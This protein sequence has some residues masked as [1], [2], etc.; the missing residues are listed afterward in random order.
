M[1]PFPPFQHLE[2][3]DLYS[4]CGQF[5][6]LTL[7]VQCSAQEHPTTATKRL[8]QFVWISGRSKACQSWTGFI[9][10]YRNLTK[11]FRWMLSLKRCSN[12]LLRLFSW[13]ISRLCLRSCITGLNRW[14]CYG[15]G[16]MIS[17]ATVGCKVSYGGIGA[18]LVCRCC[19]TGC[20]YHIWYL[21]FETHVASSCHE[22]DWLPLLVQLVLIIARLAKVKASEWRLA[23]DERWYT[24]FPIS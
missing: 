23:R 8:S 4:H 5:W 21:M 22:K 19:W 13:S 9:L 15:T 7:R 14:I 16:S 17:A 18:T 6:G 12:A 3:T 24:E 1:Q 11:F 10:I 2:R 20:Y